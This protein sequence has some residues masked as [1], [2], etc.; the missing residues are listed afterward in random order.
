MTVIGSVALTVTSF[1][2]RIALSK[3]TA[4]RSA[5]TS[6]S[7]VRTALVAGD[8]VPELNALLITQRNVDAW[9]IGNKCSENKSKSLLWKW[10]SS[11]NLKHASPII[12]V[13]FASPRDG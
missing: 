3:L 12:L 4:V 5:R 7:V 11:F 10:A 1:I 6:L 2:A 9:R 13:L 8:C